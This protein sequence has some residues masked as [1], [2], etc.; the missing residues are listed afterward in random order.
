MSQFGGR[1]EPNYLQLNMSRKNDLSKEISQTHSSILW[2]IMYIILRELEWAS[3]NE[4]T[5]KLLLSKTFLIWTNMVNNT[6]KSSKGDC[7]P[8]SIFI[9]SPGFHVSW[10]LW[11]SG[12]CKQK[13]K[14]FYNDRDR[15]VWRGSP[16][17]CKKWNRNKFRQ[18]MTVCDDLI[19]FLK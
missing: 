8:N 3:M 1:A 16:W 10:A 6:N 17:N 7:W 18:Y 5:K 19:T 4:Y 14:H 12:V 11:Q 15:K 2:R 13:S 9:S